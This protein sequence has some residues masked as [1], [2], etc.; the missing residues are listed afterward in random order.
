MNGAQ[1]I[2]LSRI[3]PQ[4]LTRLIL[5]RVVKQTLTVLLTTTAALV[6]CH[7]MAALVNNIYPSD[8]T[9]VLRDFFG[10]ER[11]GSVT[12]W[13]SSL[14]LALIGLTCGGLFISERLRSVSVAH[15]VGW[16][17]LA[18]VFL[19]LSL[20]EAAQVHERFD[21]VLSMYSRQLGVATVT[22]ITTD[23]VFIQDVGLAAYSYMLVYVPVFVGVLYLS[24]RFIAGRGASRATQ[25]LWVAGFLGFA[26]KLG[27][28][29]FEAWLWQTVWLGHNVMVEVVIIQMAA[30]LV[31][32]ALILT[33]VLGH[34]VGQVRPSVGL[35]HVA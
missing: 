17:A 4:S 12:T 6:L 3:A 34:L 27:M 1:T 8:A 13:F 7:V 30:L 19:F 25:A 22:A 10:L 26:V 35:S 5:D 16:L 14:Q 23:H 21:Q 15:A 32:E 33:A 31:G 24:R 9:A 2:G 11:E 20:D 29:P 18:V 28:E